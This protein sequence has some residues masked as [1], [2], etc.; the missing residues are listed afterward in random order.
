LG[1]ASVPPPQVAARDERS[2]QVDLPRDPLGTGFP[3]GSRAWSR[4]PARPADRQTAA[5]ARTARPPY[6]C[7]A[8]LLIAL[9]D[10]TFGRTIGFLGARPPAERT[11]VGARG[12]RHPS[13]PLSAGAGVPAPASSLS[14]SHCCRLS[15]PVGRLTKVS[16]PLLRESG[17]RDPP[18][19]RPRRAQHQGGAGHERRRSLQGAPGERR[20]LEHP[21]LGR[22]GRRPAVRSALWG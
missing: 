21:G 5:L 10:D 7:A 2:G 14:S 19:S 9:R 6:S 16:P 3:S 18:S 13:L 4:R 8:T 22:R 17:G 12:V 11:P 20:E 1:V 15:K